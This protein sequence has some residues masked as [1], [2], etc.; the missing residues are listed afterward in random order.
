MLPQRPTSLNSAQ[1]SGSVPYPAS[2]RSYD[3]IK[4]RLLARI[5][6]R[7]DPSASK[8]MPASLLRQSLRTFAEQMAEQEA[9][10]LPK[11][12]RDRMVEEVLSEL[13][14]YGPLDELFGDAEVREVMVAGP[15]A[16]IARR[17]LGN[18]VPCNVRFRDDEHLRTT[19]DR[20]ATHADTV[21][22]VTTSVN[23]FDLKLPN[24]FRAVGVIPP[25]ALGT[26][27]CVSFIRMEP[28]PAPAPIPQPWTGQPITPMPTAAAAIASDTSRSFT[29]RAASQPATPPPVIPAVSPPD[30]LV[31]HRD[32]I[33]ERLL[34]K[35]AN[36]GVYDLQRVEITELRRVVAA[37]VTEYC[38]N[39]KFYLSDA[40]QGRLQLEILTAMHR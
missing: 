4:N 2:N 15:H 31:R 8:R 40:D 23:L 12:D 22:P 26:P 11:A 20:L 34:T 13:L 5:E 24:G 38:V 28:S 18:W 32:R 36:L 10:G 39:E 1:K 35:L 21:G 17:E 30:H 3:S 6:D 27:P 19:L 37:Y 14:G 7:L 9:R 33:L 25:V 16:V 29:M